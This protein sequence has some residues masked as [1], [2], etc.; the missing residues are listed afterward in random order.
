LVENVR[1]LFQKANNKQK[2]WDVSL[3]RGIGIPL[4]SLAKDLKRMKKPS[5]LNTFYGRA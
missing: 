4:I 2:T 3:F 5:F 1:L